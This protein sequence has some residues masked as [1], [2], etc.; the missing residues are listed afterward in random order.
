MIDA[1]VVKKR[2]LWRARRALETH[3]LGEDAIRAAVTGGKG[4]MRTISSI[5]APELSAVLAYLATLTSEG[6]NTTASGEPLPAG[7]D[8]IH[9][10][11]PWET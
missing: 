6:R 10:P 3:P 5:T 11:C 4:T 1:R 8:M 9:S 7:A 2:E